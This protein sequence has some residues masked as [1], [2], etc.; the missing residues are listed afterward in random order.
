M[1]ETIKKRSRS[2]ETIVLGSGRARRLFFLGIIYAFCTS[3]SVAALGQQHL[4]DSLETLLEGETTAEN[5]QP[6]LRMLIDAY[7]EVDLTQALERANQAIALTRDPSELTAL[8]MTLSDLQ[9]M[10][11]DY[12]GAHATIDKLIEDLIAAGNN[13]A[14]A[15][16][17]RQ[18]GEVY[19]RQGEFNQSLQ[20]FMEALSLYEELQ[21]QPGIG[22]IYALM[23]DILFYQNQYAEGI[24]YGKRAIDIFKQT[25]NIDG[26]VLAYD[27]VGSNYI[28]MGDYENAI[29]ML[30]KGVRLRRES[31]PNSVSLASIVNSRGNAYKNAGMLDEALKDYQ[32]GYA[33]VARV[34]HVGGMSAISANIGDIYIRKQEWAKALPYQSKSVELMEESGFLANSLENYTNLSRVYEGLGQHDKALATL[35]KY[36]YTRDSLVTVEQAAEI[37]EL[38][39]KYEAEKKE[40]KIALQEEQISHQVRLQRLGIALFVLLGLILL[41]TIRNYLNKK[42]ANKQMAVTNRMLEKKN[43]ENEL[44]LK[45]IHHRVKNNLSIVSGLLT[46][47][48]DRVNDPDTHAVMRAT[49]NRVQAMGIL[50][51]KLYKGQN[52]DAIEMKDYL[53][54][55]SEGVLDAFDADQRIQIALTMDELELD[56]DTAV[57]IGLIVNELLTN[58]LKYAFPEERKGKV[59]IQ[60]KEINASDLLL[61]IADNGIGADFS[62][63]AQGTGFGT[64]LIQLL[65]QQL[66]GSIDTEISAGTRI[67]L[68]LKK[69]NAA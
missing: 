59:Q 2:I 60:L 13:E 12:P 58:A 47:Q 33:I 62:A 53:L 35:Q 7:A 41:Q 65:T 32:E 25:G 42:R 4:I 52:L 37:V 34:G 21:D 8:L 44:L 27:G 9:E 36:I 28:L 15:A 29:K 57:P 23:S 14:L 38:R 5:R 68:R 67:S 64:Q 69:S 46:L 56:V 51:Q 31:D 43:S 30:D 50:H 17:L 45:E 63:P 18:K 48:G 40:A 16:A 19:Q 22:R 61:E 11:S 54:N 55:L 26:L 39:T 24:E 66:Q 49:Q 6:L 10:Q 1:S 20:Q 3:L